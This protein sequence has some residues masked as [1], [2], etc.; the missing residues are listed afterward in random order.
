MTGFG[1]FSGR[2]LVSMM[3]SNRSNTGAGYGFLAA[4]VRDA[5]VGGCAPDFNNDGV[6]N[7]QDF[8][9]FLT[10][11]FAT[12]PSADFND[13]GLVNSQDFFDFLTGFFAGC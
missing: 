2:Q 5:D 3:F 4:S 9:D 11:F 13:D 8:F 6:V 1:D 10:A 7:S 12:A